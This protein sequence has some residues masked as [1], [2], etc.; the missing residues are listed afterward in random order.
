M[1]LALDILSW[2]LILGGVFFSVAGGIGMI[3]MPDLF[4]RMHAAGLIDTLGL[5]LI[6]IGLML[7]AGWTIVT[8]K[9]VLLLAFVFFTGPTGTHALAKAALH[10]GV[11]PLGSPEAVPH[12]PG[13]TL[14]VDGVTASEA[15]AEPVPRGERD[16]T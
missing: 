6:A 2:A 4:T 13:E 7:Q 11:R 10:G 8:V 12:Q 5:G 16:A 15:A 1:A 14:P 9:L 3:R